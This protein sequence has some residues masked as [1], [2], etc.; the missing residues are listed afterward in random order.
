M[1]TYICMLRGINVGGQKK[2][3]MSQLRDTF[4]GLGFE[5]VRTYIQS[6]NIVFETARSTPTR[7]SVQIEKAIAAEYGFSTP[8]LIV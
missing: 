1:S 7:L 5:N 8:A 3:K 6:G 2:M 4:S